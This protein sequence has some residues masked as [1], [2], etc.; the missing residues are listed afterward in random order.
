MGQLHKG[1]TADDTA[2]VCPAGTEEDG[3]YIGKLHQCAMDVQRLAVKAEA[4]EERLHDGTRHAQ[5]R[6][7]AQRHEDHGVDFITKRNTHGSTSQSFAFIIAKP[8]GVA[9]AM[10]DLFCDLCPVRKAFAERSE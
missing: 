5:Q 10:G 8:A 4:G 1:G 3:C 7:G 6:R 2:P 9:T